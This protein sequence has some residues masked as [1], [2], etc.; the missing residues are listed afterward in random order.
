MM[1]GR[2]EY[3]KIIMNGTEENRLMC[4][5]WKLFKGEVEVLSTSDC[6]ASVHSI[7]AMHVN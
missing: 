6:C 1:A 4:D 2:Y 5:H 7:C 3:R